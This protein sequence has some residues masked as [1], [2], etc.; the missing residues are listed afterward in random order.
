MK[1][2]K[3]ILFKRFSLLEYNNGLREHTIEADNGLNKCLEKL[4]PNKEFI[5]DKFLKINENYILNKIGNKIRPDYLCEEL[6]LIVEFDGYQHYLDPYVIY[7]DNINTELLKKLGYK[8]IRIP[9]Y[10]QL[11]NT[12][13][14]YYFDI[15]YDKENI[16]NTC[17][18]HGFLHPDIKLPSE[19][20]Y[21]GLQRFDMELLQ[22][23]KNIFSKI[24]ETI[25][26]RINIYNELNLPKNIIIPET[27]YK[28]I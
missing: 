18:D 7:K 16:Y 1:N 19:F 20:C 21:E 22:L 10:V 28:Y 24:I 27:L 8:V 2:Y 12:A 9:F 3:S 11:D 14:K 15:D 17:T 4:F 6:K 13:I 26:I 25:K 5:H 23:P